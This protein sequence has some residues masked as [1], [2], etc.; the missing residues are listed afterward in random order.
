MYMYDTHEDGT[1]IQIGHFYW[2]L[3]S[4]RR[5]KISAYFVA[6]FEYKRM[7]LFLG[8]YSIQL[9]SALRGTEAELKFFTN[10]IFNPSISIRLL[11]YSSIQL[12]LNTER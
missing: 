5:S 10:N 12:A 9:R 3:K 7:R 4:K 11:F 8:V 2:W 6:V 1:Q